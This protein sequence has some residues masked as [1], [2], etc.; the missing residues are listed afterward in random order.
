MGATSAHFSDEELQCHGSKCGPLGTGCHVNG[1]TSALIDALDAFRLRALSG[2][3]ALAPDKYFTFPGV[4][5]NDAYRC[6]Q[7]NAEVGGV[8]GSQHMLGEAADI[9]IPGMTAAQLEAIARQVP[10]IKGI[11]RADKQAYLHVD[12]RETTAQWC[13]SESGAQCP[14][15]PPVS[16]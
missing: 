13:Y 12:V 15:Y 3:G 5:V 10:A 14:Y 7:H 2:W 16:A 9:R 8:K 11:G 1:C 6:P 4:I